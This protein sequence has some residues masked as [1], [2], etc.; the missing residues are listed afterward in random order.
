MHLR[1]GKGIFA[2]PIVP[3]GCPVLIGENALKG[4]QENGMCLVSPR[5]RERERAERVGSGVRDG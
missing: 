3:K 5:E 1:K 4:K 2:K